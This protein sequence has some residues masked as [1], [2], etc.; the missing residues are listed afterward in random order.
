MD[1]G[2]DLGNERDKERRDCANTVAER[3]AVQV[4]IQILTNPATTAVLVRRTRFD[5]P[6]FLAAG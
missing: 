4:D 1:H 2:D 3:V 5:G 6:V